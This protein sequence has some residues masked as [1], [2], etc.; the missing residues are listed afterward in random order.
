MAVAISAARLILLVL[1]ATSALVLG[2]D[3]YEVLQV[4][5]GATD[6]QIKRSYRKLALQ[7]HPDKVTGSDEEKANAA[8][9]FAEINNA[10]EALSDEEKRRIY[11]QHGEEGLKQH[12]QQGGQRHGGGFGDLF[13]GFFGGGFGQQEE[14]RTPKGHDV[15][16][17]LYVTLKDLYIGKELKVTRDK[18]VIKPAPGT[19]QC[20]CKMKLVTKQ[21]GPGMFQQFQQQVCENCPNVKLDRE[22][23]VLTVHVEPGMNPGQM[24]TFFEEGEPIVD[25]EPGDLK[26]VIRSPFDGRWERRSA[27]LIINETI[28]LVDALTGFSREIEHLDGHKVRI[29]WEKVTKPGDYQYIANEGMPVYNTA[30]RYGNLFVYYFIDF[31]DVLTPEQKKLIRDLFGAAPAA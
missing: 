1:V 15:Y 27:D 13:G 31:P 23:E 8:K 5:R 14:E 20:K 6:A 7:Y 26:F 22:S 11:D 12:S 30:D 21:L 4:P 19:R 18:A 3:Y 17:D 25:G 28:S 10:Y 29:G 9:L 24:I 2:K 16:A